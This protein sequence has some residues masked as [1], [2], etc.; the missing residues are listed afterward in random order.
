MKREI[1]AFVFA[2]IITII[3]FFS[4]IYIGKLLAKSMF[5]E[6]ENEILEIMNYV[7][8]VFLAEKLLNFTSCDNITLEPIFETVSKLGRKLTVLEKELGVY[9]KKVLLIKEYYILSLLE[10]YRLLEEYNKRCGYKYIPILFFYSNDKEYYKDSIETGK[11]LDYFVFK[12]N[13]IK[14]FSIEG[15]LIDNPL[16]RMLKEKYNITIF[17]TIVINDSIII[18]GVPDIKTLEKYLG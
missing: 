4:G 10:S 15:K 18:A 12:N 17:P 2:M 14:V 8:S 7:N 16:I 11:I 9:D 13:K 5:L 1:K 3:A 6:V